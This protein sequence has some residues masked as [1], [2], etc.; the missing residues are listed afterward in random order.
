MRGGGEREQATIVQ[1]GRKKR[2]LEAG[3]WTVKGSLCLYF[4]QKRQGKIFYVERER[5]EGVLGREG[6][7]V[8]KEDVEFFPSPFVSTAERACSELPGRKNLG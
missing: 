5:Q 7:T 2:T 4:A 8:A 3:R 6:R 1:Q